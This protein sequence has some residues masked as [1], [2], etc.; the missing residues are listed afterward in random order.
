M[1]PSYA[2]NPNDS[3]NPHGGTA[4]WDFQIF[5]YLGY[6]EIPEADRTAYLRR[7]PRA[8][9]DIFYCPASLRRD[10]NP[11]YSRSYFFNVNLAQ[12]NDPSDRRLSTLV[13]PSRTAMI[14]ELGYPAGSNMSLNIGGGTNN[15][16]YF[17][18]SSSDLLPYFRHSGHINILF[19]DG[20][21]EGTKARPGGSPR[22][23][24]GVA[25]SNSIRW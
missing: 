9:H 8:L 10:V 13:A 6:S 17:R 16:M 1:F 3:L 23:P 19:A 11:D 21:A 20:H 25:F 12:G 14:M 2:E 5:P 18:S 4:Q 7:T 22:W 24:E 15:V